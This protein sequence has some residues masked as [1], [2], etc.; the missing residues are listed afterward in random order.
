M[1]SYRIEA[2]ATQR[3][4]ESQPRRASAFPGDAVE[5]GTE[6]HGERVRFHVPY[7]VAIHGKHNEDRSGSAQAG[8]RGSFELIIF[9]RDIDQGLAGLQD[10]RAGHQRYAREKKATPAARFTR[11]SARS[12]RP[13]LSLPPPH[14]HSFEVWT[15]DRGYCW[16]RPL[17]FVQAPVGDP[18]MRIARR[19]V[20]GISLAAALL[21]VPSART[22]MA[23]E[24]ARVA[25]QWYCRV[26]HHYHPN[27]MVICPYNP[28]ES[29]CNR[30]NNTFASC[31]SHLS[32][33]TE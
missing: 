27:S 22:L 26:C 13:G 2:S 14:H 20:T 6:Q 12:E 29:L 28:S 5:S 9:H 1:I 17:H 3:Q 7:S 24:C 18:F 11:G 15:T 16:Q 30:R 10:E 33:R 23:Q 25:G 31:C 8:S 4:Q 21:A 32:L 19:A